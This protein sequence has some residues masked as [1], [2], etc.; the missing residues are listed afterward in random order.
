MPGV[1]VGVGRLGGHDAAVA[2]SDDDGRLV[3][4]LEEGLA[5]LDRPELATL[6]LATLRGL[7]MDLGAT[8]DAARTA[9]AQRDLL[10]AIRA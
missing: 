8:G 5:S 9:R 2:V 6:V 1:D 10:D 7:L 4:G 3:L